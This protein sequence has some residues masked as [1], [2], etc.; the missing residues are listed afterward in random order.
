[1]TSIAPVANFEGRIGKTG[2]ILGGRTDPDTGDPI[3]LNNSLLNVQRTVDGTYLQTGPQLVG[4]GNAIK[5]Y[6]SYIIEE[7]EADPDSFDAWINLCWIQRAQGIGDKFVMNLPSRKGDEVIRSLG[8][9]DNDLI[10]RKSCNSATF[11]DVVAERVA[12]GT[13]DDLEMKYQRIRLPFTDP[14]FPESVLELPVRNEEAR[15]IVYE[16][17]A[18]ADELYLVLTTDPDDVQ[19]ETGD[20]VGID[21]AI[22]SNSQGEQK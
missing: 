21:I 12:S 2:M 22:G 4:M 17:I 20:F 19:G 8:P 1:M 14:P 5:I 18:K 9:I 3:Y 13:L 10:I 11:Y 7:G 6:I 16:C 15:G